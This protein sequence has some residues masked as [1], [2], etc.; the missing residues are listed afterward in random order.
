VLRDAVDRKI[1]KRKTHRDH[2]NY[3]STRGEATGVQQKVDLKLARITAVI[4][5]TAA[6]TF[7]SLGAGVSSIGH[8]IQTIRPYSDGTAVGALPGLS[9]QSS[10]KS[11]R[12]QR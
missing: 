5:C 9:G 7:R 8:Y 2:P 10:E 6:S 11:R 12:F 4:H 1:K 3:V